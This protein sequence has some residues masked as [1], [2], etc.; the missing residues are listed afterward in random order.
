[1]AGIV[2]EP[3]VV[4]LSSF[5]ETLISRVRGTM[6]KCTYIPCVSLPSC[7]RISGLLGEIYITISRTLFSSPL[8][9]LCSFG[10]GITT[11]FRTF[12]TFRF[13]IITFALLFRMLI[14]VKS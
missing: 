5:I 9:R 13:I 11:M 2:R 7:L 3:S 4:K 12:T 6:N 1:M 14:V 10:G 8:G